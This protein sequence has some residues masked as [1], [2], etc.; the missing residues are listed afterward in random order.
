MVKWTAPLVAVVDGTRVGLEYRGGVKD[1]VAVS[2]DG[3]EF[4]AEEQ[5]RSLD[6]A[7]AIAYGVS[8]MMILKGKELLG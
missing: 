3:S 5:G 2:K 7:L 4:D 1:R 8:A 6:D